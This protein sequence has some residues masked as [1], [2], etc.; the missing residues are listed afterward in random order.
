MM[1]NG[2]RTLNVQPGER[3]LSIKFG[4]FVHCE[5]GFCCGEEREMEECC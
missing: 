1:F 3:T 5:R 4:I 2:G